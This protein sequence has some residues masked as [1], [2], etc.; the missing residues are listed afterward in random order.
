M[1]RNSMD[2]LIS[3]I[4]PVKDGSN[5]IHQALD[6]IISQDI[7]KEIIVVDDN[8]NDNTSQIAKEKGCTV[9][10]NITTKGPAEC[11]NIG[12]K[13][14]KGNYIMFHDHDDVINKDTLR[15]LYLELLQNPD[16]Y[17]V[18]AKLED[19]ISPE[20]SAQEKTR[21]KAKK[22]A[23]YGLFSGAILIRKRTFDIIGPFNSQIHAGDI[24]DWQLKMQSH[25]LKTKKLDLVAAN[26]RLH[27]ANFGRTR[28]NEE[29]KDYASLLRANLSTN[30]KQ[31]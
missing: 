21:L 4:I 14:A 16:I 13:H 31:S 10:K 29:Y 15:I 26:R 19:F 22:E 17:A 11:K 2:N 24:I 28:K 5:Y 6:A 9:I 3:I 18:M 25:N 20:L 1:R 12:L 27:A 23:Y 8:S 7:L 30:S